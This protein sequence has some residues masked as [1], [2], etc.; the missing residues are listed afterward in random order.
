MQQSHPAEYNTANWVSDLEGPPHAAYCKLNLPVWPKP[1]YPQLVG[2]SHHVPNVGSRQLS[3]ADGVFLSAGVPSRV[4]LP[5]RRQRSM[6]PLVCVF[7][8]GAGGLRGLALDRV[9]QYVRRDGHA[10]GGCTAW[11]HCSA[12]DRTDRAHV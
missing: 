7:L 11:I 12:D 9:R 3:N 6:A 2:E 4:L 10:C 5:A 1:V 8:G